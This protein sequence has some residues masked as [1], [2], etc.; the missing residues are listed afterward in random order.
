MT[1]AERITREPRTQAGHEFLAN[2]QGR[3]GGFDSE[4]WRMTVE[5]ILAIEAE[6]H[7]QALGILLMTGSPGEHYPL[8]V[9]SH[10]NVKQATEAVERRIGARVLERMRTMRHDFQTLPHAEF[11]VKWPDWRDF[12]EVLP[13]HCS[14]KDCRLW[15]SGS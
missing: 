6:A 4:S 11:P 2:L 13:T 14:C 12:E 9:M 1:D 5:D 15:R 7:D 10:D 8:S 3:F